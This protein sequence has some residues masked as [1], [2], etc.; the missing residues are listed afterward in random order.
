MKPGK[1][2]DRLSCL[3]MNPHNREASAARRV[4]LLAAFGTLDEDTQADLL[5]AVETMVFRARAGVDSERDE[6]RRII[7]QIYKI[8]GWEE[9][10]RG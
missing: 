10:Y 6:A 7:E 5:E 9:S 4:K 8:A 2:A 3:A 1:G